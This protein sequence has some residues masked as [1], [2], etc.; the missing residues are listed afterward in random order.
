VKRK[1]KKLTEKLPLISIVTPS[2]N[3][4]AYIEE[5]IKSVLNQQYP[6][7][8]HIIIDG[9]STDGTIDILKKYDHLIW[10]SEKDNGQSQA[11]N[12]GFKRARGEI[13]G[14]LNSDDYYEPGA[15][16]IIVQELCK[17]EGKYIV[18][19]DCKVVNGKGE[20]IGY[21][22][23][24][25][26][27]PSNFIKYWDRDYRIPQP[28]VFFYKDI[29]G[30]V[31]FLDEELQYVMD[32]DFWLRVTKYY[33]LH[34]IEQTL[35]AMRVHDRAKTSLS[36]ELFERE[37]FKILR[38]YS[39]HRFSIDNYR[40]LLLALNFRSNLTRINAYSKKEVLPLREF[41]KKILLSILIN[42]LNLFSRKFLSALFRAMLGHQ[43]SNRV[44]RFVSETR[45]FK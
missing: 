18:V 3:Q 40:Y 13:I 28:A 42:P 35:A 9:G 10:V 34:Y 7:F 37:W 1:G 4:G 26:T 27:H 44:K 38:K 39:L 15:F 19:G 8:E 33:Q 43:R 5:A 30:R 41:R 20:K 2:L 22:K 31:G 14:W 6:N 23:A 36:Y 29:I 24:K 21:C 17:P 32:Y 25:L 11:I 16:I 12:K 45:V